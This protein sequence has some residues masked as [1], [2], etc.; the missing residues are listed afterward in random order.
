MPFTA[1]LFQ[2]SF[3]HDQVVSRA[4]LMG[5]VS[6][7]RALLTVSLR[8]RS[9]AVCDPNGQFLYDVTPPLVWIL[10]SKFGRS[11]KTVTTHQDGP[12]TICEYKQVDCDG[13]RHDIETDKP[14]L[15]WFGW[16]RTVT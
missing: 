5:T 10:G 12:V 4:L 8:F 3:L 11:C 7:A 16:H 1:P 14:C 13:P 6:F 15:Q 2:P 9:C